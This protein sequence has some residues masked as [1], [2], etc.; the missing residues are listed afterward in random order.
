MVNPIQS[1]L[2]TS[3]DIELRSFKNLSFDLEGKII[4][5]GMFLKLIIAA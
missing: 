1:I 3:G 2:D 4:T 5:E